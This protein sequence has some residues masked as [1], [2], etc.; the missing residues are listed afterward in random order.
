MTSDETTVTAGTAPSPAPSPWR[1]WRPHGPYSCCAAGLPKIMWMCVFSC[2]FGVRKKKSMSRN[3]ICSPVV[4]K[5]D[6]ARVYIDMLRL[7]WSDCL[8]LKYLEITQPQIKHWDPKPSHAHTYRWGQPQSTNFEEYV[9]GTHFGA[10]AQNMWLRGA[11]IN[12]FISNAWINF[13]SHYL[14]GSWS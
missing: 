11:V 13:K 9:A 10:W 2:F 7:N 6:C 14:D 4:R 5:L 12:V 1:P 8:T 3:S